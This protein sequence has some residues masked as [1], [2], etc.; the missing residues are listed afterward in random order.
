MSFKEIILFVYVLY[1]F[2]IF[3][4]AICVSLPTFLLWAE[5]DNIITRIKENKITRI[6]EKKK[7]S[8]LF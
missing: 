6:K 1:E 3:G 8:E 4:Q 7:V 5:L 2:L